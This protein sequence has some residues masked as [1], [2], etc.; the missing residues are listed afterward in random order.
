MD[1]PGF[2]QS[3]GV[4]KPGAIAHKWVNEAA[5]RSYMEKTKVFVFIISNAN[6]ILFLFPPQEF[7]LIRFLVLFVIDNVR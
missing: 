4:L 6:Q 1:A 2:G 3:R 7:S 5:C